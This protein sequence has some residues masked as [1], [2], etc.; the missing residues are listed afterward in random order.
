MRE[1]EGG[2]EKKRKVPNWSTSLDKSAFLSVESFTKETL[3][4]KYLSLAR[5]HRMQNSMSEQKNL[6]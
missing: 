1:G 2:K 5:N 6:K 4:V 3:F